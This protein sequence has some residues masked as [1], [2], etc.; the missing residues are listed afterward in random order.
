MQISEVGL[1]MSRWPSENHFASW[2]GLCPT[3]ENDS[4]EILTL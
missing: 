1:D 2:L 3:P 4:N